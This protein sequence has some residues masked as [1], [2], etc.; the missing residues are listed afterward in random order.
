MVLF[1][2]QQRKEIF[3]MGIVYK[4][5]FPDGKDYIGSTTKSIDLRIKQHT[6][7]GNNIYFPTLTGLSIK[8]FGEFK[9]EILDEIDCIKS[10]RAMEKKRI[11]EHKTMLPHG[12]N[13]SVGDGLN[14]KKNEYVHKTNRRM[15][16][17]QK[18]AVS[19][20]VMLS[21]ERLRLWHV[22]YLE[23]RG[24]NIHPLDMNPSKNF[25]ESGLTV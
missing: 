15:T 1:T 16:D 7:A 19:N 24:I 21:R 23:E 20:G 18:K 5:S 10:L 11:R 13:I 9:V 14:L 6:Y 25:I 2:Q 17:E 12:L 4:L 8:K 3:I 22:N